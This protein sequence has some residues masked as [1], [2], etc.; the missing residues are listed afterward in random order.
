MKNK[1]PKTDYVLEILEEIRDP[2]NRRNL[3]GICS[4]VQKALTRRFGSPLGGG[5][6]FD[7][8][9]EWHSFYDASVKKWSKYSGDI[10]YPVPHPGDTEER[11]DREPD[12]FE[13]F[14]ALPLWE[15]K[16]GEL[17]MEFLDYLIET[18]KSKSL[19]YWRFRTFLR[20]ILWSVTW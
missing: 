10:H 12:P 19:R 5:L 18:R 7:T 6:R 17:R 8:E 9:M 11:F 16:Y 4:N 13:A 3:S 2:K 15:G 1:L 14:K 20:S